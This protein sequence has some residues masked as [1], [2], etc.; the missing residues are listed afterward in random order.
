LIYVVPAPRSWVCSGDLVPSHALA[1]F[2]GELMQLKDPR[3]AE[4]M[5]SWGVYYRGLPLE[6]TSV[7]GTSVDGEPLE[8]EPS[9]ASSEGSRPEA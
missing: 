5:Q 4:L 1:G 6:G 2:F 3:V 7:E 8:I 9:E